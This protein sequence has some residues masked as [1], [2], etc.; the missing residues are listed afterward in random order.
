TGEPMDT[1]VI[2]E[3]ET[4]ASVIV[5]MGMDGSIMVRK[6]LT[7]F[8]STFIRKYERRIL[9][10]AWEQL[11]EERDKRFGSSE[12][13]A[14][15]EA[16]EEDEQPQSDGTVTGLVNGA[17]ANGNGD[18]SAHTRSVSFNTVDTAT[19]SD[20]GV[21]K[22]ASVVVDFVI[23]ALLES[24]LGE[25]ANNILDDLVVAGL[26]RDQL[27]LSGMDPLS[28]QRSKDTR[29]QTPPSPSAASTMSKQDGGG[30]FGLSRTASV[31]AA[32]K[33]FFG[34]GAKTPTEAST[35]PTRSQRN[36]V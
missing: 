32:M 33:N 26:K 22:N 18:R 7:I 20:T 13:G 24:P 29:P 23:N 11:L 2:L 34:G 17:L 16:D 6:E 35:S 27:T 1:A 5:A 28:K 21:A 25:H 4:L 36:S 14:D 3:E 15:G 9:V 8:Y 10:A 30:Y 31:A 12:S 19:S